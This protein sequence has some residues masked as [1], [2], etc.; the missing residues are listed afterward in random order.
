MMFR[1]LPL[2]AIVAC[3]DDAATQVVNGAAP[4]ISNM[5][6]MPDTVKVGQ[7]VSLQGTVDF[8]D[9]DG[10]L[11]TLVANLKVGG[12]SISSE[13]AVQNLTGQKSGTAALGV[14]LVIPSE[15]PVELSAT[16][17][18]AKGNRSNTLT[19]IVQATN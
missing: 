15:G 6:L 19:K 10:D 5:V 9:A 1:L 12:Q 14:T 11:K 13:S 7:Q 18:D 16:L 3:S 4:K 17:V 2:L 8:E